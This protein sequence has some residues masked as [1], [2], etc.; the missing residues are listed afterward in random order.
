MVWLFPIILFYEINYFQLIINNVRAG[1]FLMQQNTSTY[2]GLQT[3]WKETE[4]CGLSSEPE[5]QVLFCELI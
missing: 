1:K 5:F 2:Q 4:V 3:S